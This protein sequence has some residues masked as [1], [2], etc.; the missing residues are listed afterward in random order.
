MYQISYPPVNGV[1]LGIYLVKNGLF[2]L[3]TK[4]CY[5][6]ASISFHYLVLATI[7]IKLFLVPIPN[8]LTVVVLT[9]NQLNEATQVN[10]PIV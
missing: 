5:Q 2:C 8:K 3:L 10:T 1:S 4:I 6:N 9:I 7:K